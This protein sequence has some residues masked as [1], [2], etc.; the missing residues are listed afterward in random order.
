MVRRQLPECSRDLK[1]CTKCKTLKSLDEFHNDRTRPGGKCY[2]CKKCESERA[3][4]FYIKNKEKINRKHREYDRANKDKIRLQKRVSNL[5]R[6]Y[7]LT[8]QEW[9]QICDS[10]QNICAICKKLAKLVVDHCHKSGKVRGA[11]CDKCNQALGL[12]YENTDSLMNAITYLE[13]NK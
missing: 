11:L 6:K 3:K 13:S 5:R 12:F 4:R 9:N 1:T 10:Q 7:D 8:I 2:C